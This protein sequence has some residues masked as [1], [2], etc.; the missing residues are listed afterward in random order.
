[1]Q[2]IF[3]MKYD[4]TIPFTH[5]N[6]SVAAL[7]SLFQKHRYSPFLTDEHLNICSRVAK[8]NHLQDVYKK[9]VFKSYVEPEMCKIEESNT[10][11][12]YSYVPLR[13]LCLK[14]LSN[15]SV[16][17]HLVNEQQSRLNSEP[18]VY[19]SALDGEALSARLKGK[20]KLELY[21]DD[22]NLAPAGHHGSSRQ[23]HLF[24]YAT[25]SDLPYH[26]RTQMKDIELIMMVNRK[27][28]KRF[29]S[30]GML[31]LFERLKAD[32]IEL[33]TNG[34]SISI[35][36]QQLTVHLELS[37]IIGDNLAI[38]EVLGYKLCFNNNAY[39]CRYCSA[40]GN[41]KR[42]A[43]T[44]HSS[45]HIYPLVKNIPTNLNTEQLKDQFGIVNPFLLEGVPGLMRLNIC[46]PDVVHDLAEGVIPKTLQL[47]L[48]SL[49][50]K[51]FISQKDVLSFVESYSYFYEG[52]PEVQA[53]GTFDFKIKG[54]AIQ[55]NL[56][57][58]SFQYVN[59]FLYRNSSFSS[60]FLSFCLAF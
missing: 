35:G 11:V 45:E 17:K 50:K 22:C 43:D 8:S 51:S 7:C 19:Q 31:K 13:S 53:S 32:L 14:Y 37:S 28:L 46:P 2:V 26:F 33:S 12:N 9:H 34:I 4:Y 15:G 39:V 21:L 29:G 36:N 18:T 24:V 3:K 48:R 41:L 44:I 6:E 42:I 55:V 38:N 16:V 47:I 54:K 58:L 20:L 52:A 60:S 23:E 27:E 10:T 56:T 30:G 5:V 57:F 40:G 25:F 1:M 49:V 59:I